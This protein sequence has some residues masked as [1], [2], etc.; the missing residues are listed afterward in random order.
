MSKNIKKLLIKAQDAEVIKIES[1]EGNDDYVT[2]SMRTGEGKGKQYQLCF[3]GNPDNDHR[4][5]ERAMRASDGVMDIQS[6]ID[7]SFNCFAV[8]MATTCCAEPPNNKIFFII[9]PLLSTEY[10]F[11]ISL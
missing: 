8:S 10:T 2:F 6:M 1:P 4:M 7:S 5:A 3:T 9:N 11:M